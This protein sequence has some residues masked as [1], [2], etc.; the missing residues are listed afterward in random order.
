[1]STQENVF[2]RNG[3]GNNDTFMNLRTMYI[4]LVTIHDAAC[5]IK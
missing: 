2:V 5:T 3:T 4:N 1:M